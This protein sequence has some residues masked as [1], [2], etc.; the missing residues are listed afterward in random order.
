MRDTAT[1]R[2]STIHNSV[3]HFVDDGTNGFF[4]ETV[5]ADIDI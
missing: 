1:P 3:A 4:K 5:V 2:A